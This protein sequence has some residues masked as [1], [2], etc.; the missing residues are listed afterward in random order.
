MSQVDESKP[1]STGG[2]TVDDINLIKKTVRMEYEV[3]INEML[4]KH[5]RVLQEREQQIQSQTEE[6]DQLRKFV[7]EQKNEIQALN[8]K[9]DQK[10]SETQNKS[11][12][13]TQLMARI[14]ELNEIC[15][16]KEQT[17]L[18]LSNEINSMMLKEE[19]FF[20]QINGLESD[21]SYSNAQIDKAQKHIIDLEASMKDKDQTS[22]KLKEENSNLNKNFEKLAQDNQSLVDTINKLKKE[23]QN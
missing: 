18:K 17:N 8:Q 23:L 3:K 16:G 6:L 1:G 10:D 2:F 21:L 20:D 5:G 7:L 19:Q 15:A 12:S 22:K 4:D 14:K 9:I 11:K 13:E